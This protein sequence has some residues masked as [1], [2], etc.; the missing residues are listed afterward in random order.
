MLQTRKDLLQAHR[1]MTRRAALAL[2]QAEPDPPDQPLRR[3]NVSA[4]SSLLVAV[5]VAAVFGIWGLVAPGHAGGLTAPDTLLIDQATGTPFVPCQHGKLC[6]VV[7]YASARLALNT[8]TP[9]QQQVSQASLARYPRG[10]E[11][12]IEGLPALPATSMLVGQP[13]SVCVQTETSAATLASHTMTTLVGGQ[14]V[15][16]R[17]MSGG[18]ALVVAAGGEDWL[19]WNGERMLIPPVQQAAILT[20]LGFVQTAEQVPLSWL[21]AFSR[22]PDFAPPKIIGFGKRVLRGP[23]G[24]PAQLGQVF[25]TSPGARQYYV[26]T[27]P[28]LAPV[29]V[30]EAKLLEAI[31]GQVAQGTVTTAQAANHHGSVSAD[32]MPLTMPAP[33]DRNISPSAPLCVVYSG[34]ASTGPV[35]GRVTVGGR[36]PANG[37]AVTGAGYVNQIAMRPGTAALVGVVPG[38]PSAGSASSPAPSSQRPDVTSY[39]LVTGGVRYGLAAPGV[40]AMLGYNLASQ[41]TLVP[42]SVVDLIPRGPA[43]DPAAARDRVAG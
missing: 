37:L 23:A 14:R 25:V 26:L 9:N 15:G 35:A 21:D 20:A 22:G 17:P 31:P 34:P 24:G 40:A 11:I 12:G 7:N 27:R 6:P 8:A 19:V 29:T 36:V 30:T 32:G 28:G 10:P 13:W 3:L 41:Q 33:A 2:L 16:G 18:D 1:L 42:A 38:M 39:F 5:I 43:F 4:F